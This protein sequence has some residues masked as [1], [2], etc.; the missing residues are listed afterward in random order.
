MRTG[1]WASLLVLA[2]ALPVAAQQSITLA[3]GATVTATVSGTETIFR[4]RAPH[5]NKTRT[6]ALKR[7]ETVAKD[8]RTPDLKLVGEVPG[9]A[10]LLTDTYPSQASGLAECQA[11]EEQFLR[12]ITTAGQRLVESYHVKLASCREDIEL[13]SPGLDWSES[14][15]TLTVD[16]LAG[17]HAADES[18]KP[19]ETIT[20]ET[21]T[22]DAN[23]RATVTRRS[24]GGGDPRASGY[25]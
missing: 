7:D 21:I 6:L 18:G 2:A 15:R 10:I 14:K 3:S 20:S 25:Y 11:G 4:L 22:I 24:A 9:K 5:K 12:V 23:G 17:P 16:W 19:G 8:T 1:S 13:G